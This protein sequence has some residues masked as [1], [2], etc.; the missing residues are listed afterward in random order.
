MT[1]SNL[2]TLVKDTTTNYINHPIHK[3]LSYEQL[4][5]NALEIVEM[6]CCFLYASSHTLNEF[7]TVLQDFT[8]SISKGAKKLNDKPFG[9]AENVTLIDQIDAHIDMLYFLFGNT[10]A[11]GIHPSQALENISRLNEYSTK[12]IPP[13]TDVYADKFIGVDADKDYDR[14]LLKKENYDYYDMVHEFHTVFNHPIGN[15]TS[16]RTT[17]AKNR[18]VYYFEEVLESLQVTATNATIFN[19]SVKKLQAKLVNVSTNFFET[20]LPFPL[21]PESRAAYQLHYTSTLMYFA[22][23][24]FAGLSIDPLPFFSIVHEA[25]MDKVGI[26][27]KPIYD[28]E[29]GKVLKR[30]GWQAPEP[31]LHALLDEIL[32]SKN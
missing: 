12:F 8:Q 7:R 11:L 13:F 30:E 2:Y 9:T 27:G 26:D 14:S 28:L 1:K 10:V 24:V 6:A 17:L 22:F 15:T 3:P 25:N 21:S 18:M 32:N 23:E 19:D 20:N 16:M 31:K 5:A 29:T 4:E